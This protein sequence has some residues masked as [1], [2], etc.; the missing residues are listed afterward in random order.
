M[1]FDHHKRYP[2]ANL[3]TDID[4]GE[5]TRLYK[6]GGGSD[7]GRHSAA[8]TTFWNLRSRQS[9]P[10]FPAGFGPDLMTTV[11]L[12]SHDPAVRDASGLWFEPVDPTTL[13]PQ[14][15]YDAQRALRQAPAP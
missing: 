13:Q 9:V 12:K 8:W 14:N 4:V 7:L 2:H 5:G 1:S 10:K 11:G 3:F 15:L 6:C